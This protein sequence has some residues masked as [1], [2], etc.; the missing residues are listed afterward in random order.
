[1]E[2]IVTKISTYLVTNSILSLFYPSLGI[3]N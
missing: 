2:L 3:K 1:M